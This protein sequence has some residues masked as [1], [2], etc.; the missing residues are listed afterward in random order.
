MRMGIRLETLQVQIRSKQNSV[1]M[2]NNLDG[3]T[4]ILELQSTDMPIEQLYGKLENFNKAFDDL[5]IKGNIL[6]DGMEKA[7]GQ[8]GQ[9]K[10]VDNM[11]KGLQA[12]VQMDLGINPQINID[13]N[14][15]ANTNT[16]KQTEAN[17]DFYA[18]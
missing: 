7:L 18:G 8:P 4:P 2:V 15:N 5:T 11:M 16:Y 3:I 10:N 6:D 12:E 1:D 13:A 17:D 14:A 9:T